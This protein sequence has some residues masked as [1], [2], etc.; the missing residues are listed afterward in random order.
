MVIEEGNGCMI[1]WI[2]WDMDWGHASPQDLVKTFV[3]QRSSFGAKNL[4]PKQK[5]ESPF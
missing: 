1:G 5:I 4:N 3:V 2:F